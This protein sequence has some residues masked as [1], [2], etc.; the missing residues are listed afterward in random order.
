MTD[1]EKQ[2]VKSECLGGYYLTISLIC[3]AY[4]R[5]GQSTDI[6]IEQ[7]SLEFLPVETRIPLKFGAEVLTSVT[8]ARVGVE[9]S[10]QVGDHAF[11]WGET[12]L[13][14]QWV[15]PSELAYSIRQLALIEFCKI[16]SVR[17]NSFWGYGHCLELG[18]RL[19][20]EDLPKALADRNSSDQSGN[21]P[22]PW[23]AALVCASAFDLAVHDSYGVI[24]RV[25]TYQA[26]GP[27]FLS[28]DLSCYL[29]P[30]L[31]SEVCFSNRYPSDFL[32]LDPPNRLPVWHLV[33]G[34]D[35]LCEDEL[36][37]DEPKDGYPVH[38]REWIERDGL[39]CLKIKLRGDDSDWD[40]RRLVRVGRLSVELGVEHLSADFNCTV[41]DPAYVNDI[42]DKLERDFFE[43]HRRILYIE[44][45]FPHDLK[46]HPIEVHSVSE[47]KPLF[48]DESA[49]DWKRVV[50][51]RELGWTGV[52]LK[53][54]KTQTGALLS[55][56]WAKAHEMELMVQDLT[57]PR[58]AQ[59]SHVLLGV[60]AGT[61]MG[62]E[63]NAMQFYPDASVREARVHPGLFSRKK[64]ELDRSS[65][66]GPGFGYRMEEIARSD[67]LN[68]MR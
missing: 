65:L 41:T 40:I 23:L 13:S 64:G 66:R 36:S 34:L 44:Q 17:W 52:A 19:V 28:S 55:L 26:Y 43:T 6:R 14:V 5:M 63:S 50:L 20:M 16:L 21:E 67:Q 7:F 27:E 9:V 42:L 49:H 47:R 61:I 39:N 59:I 68:Q 54:C 3:T 1:S 24:N 51:G 2:G 31:N 58:L 32:V 8:C 15:W 33:G 29:K 22:M 4:L 45:P 38:L 11:G 46:K 30:A 35:P 60:H 18:H 37:G 53:T 25:A 56:C 10:N 57:N 12:P 62:V 48:M